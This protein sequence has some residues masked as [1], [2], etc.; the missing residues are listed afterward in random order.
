M[1]GSIALNAN[2]IEP[3]AGVKDRIVDAKRIALAGGDRCVAELPNKGGH[4]LRKSVHAVWRNP[5][6]GLTVRSDAG[7]QRPAAIEIALRYRPRELEIALEIVA[8]SCRRAA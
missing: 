6:W 5:L 4:C 8:L 1:P 3:R 2:A 7:A